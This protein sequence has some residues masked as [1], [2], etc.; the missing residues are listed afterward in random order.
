M[1]EF[2]KSTTTATTWRNRTPHSNPTPSS[3]DPLSPLPSIELVE[4]ALAICF[5]VAST[6][7]QILNNLGLPDDVFAKVSA[8][9]NTAGYILI[10]AAAF[11]LLSLGLVFI[12]SLS[13]DKGFDESGYDHESLLGGSGKKND[14]F[15]A[16]G[17]EMGSSPSVP[18]AAERYREKHSSYYSKYGLGK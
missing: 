7:T 1:V 10:S 4:I 2:F 18:T 8:N 14:K 16:L 11:L 3:P 5:Q 13:L 9:T 6:R 12:Q 17:D 15:G